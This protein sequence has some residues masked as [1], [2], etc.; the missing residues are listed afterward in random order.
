MLPAPALSVRKL[1]NTTPS[2]PK[3]LPPT[4]VKQR[5]AVVPEAKAAY[6]IAEAKALPPP[7]ALSIAFVAAVPPVQLA[8]ETVPLNVTP[9]MTEF[10]PFVAPW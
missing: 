9:V 6:H 10:A 7:K 4:A 3:P 2:A 1:T 5:V 8:P